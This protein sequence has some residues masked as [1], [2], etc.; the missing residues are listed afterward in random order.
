MPDERLKRTGDVFIEVDCE[1]YPRSKFWRS[2]FRLDCRPDFSHALGSADTDILRTIIRAGCCVTR[3]EPQMRARR[4]PESRHAPKAAGQRIRSGLLAAAVAVLVAFTAVSAHAL[5]PASKA[6]PIEFQADQLTYDSRNRITIATGNVEAVQQGR[7]VVADKMTYDEPRNVLTAEGNVVLYEPTG[8]VVHA[9]SMQLTGD[10]KNAIIEN[11]RAVLADGSR[12]TAK[13]GERIGGTVTTAEDGSYTPCFA[14]AEDPERTP[15]WQVRAVRVTH[16][17]IEKTIEFS[18]AWLEFVGVPVGYVPYLTQPDPS[19]KRK[20]G[21]LIPTFGESSDLGFLIQ[22]PYFVVLSDS[23]DM[24]ITPWFTSN[25][26]PVLEAQYRQALQHGKIDFRGSGTYDSQ[27]RALGHVFGEARYDIDETWRAGLDVQRATGRT[28][29]RRYNFDSQRTLTSR[30]YGE[31]FPNASDYFIGR[32]IAFQNQEHDTDDKNIPYVAPWLDYFLV[33]DKDPLGGQTEVRLDSAVLT[34]EQGLDTRRL[35][36]RAEWRR[37]FVGPIGDLVTVSGAMWADGYNVDDLERND[38]NSQFSGNSGRLFPQ[39]GVEWRLP[40]VRQGEAVHQVIEPITEV[41]LAPTYGNSSRIPNED[42]QDFELQD[43]NLFGFH[44]LPGIDRVDKGP[45]VNYGLNY[46]LYAPGGKSA[47]AF[48]GQSYSFTGDDDFGKGTGLEDKTSDIVSALDLTPAP[49]FDIVY[50]N[51]I[52]HSSFKFERN[53]VG[54]R[55][56]NEALKLHGT[57]VRYESQPQNDLV[58][59]EEVEYGLDTRW[60]RFWRTRAFGITDIRSESQRE[61]GLRAIYEDECFLFSAEFSRENFKDKDVE[62]TNVVFFRVGFKTL[63]DIGAG[64]NPGGS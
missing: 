8:E 62:P 45:R 54:A 39:A 33:T 31:A 41:I 18:H 13:Q 23:Q 22:V 46:T 32:A 50:R 47:S 57:Y 28:Y 58:G 30:L 49:W 6:Q 25:E 19:V 51:R 14:C 26:G 53:E 34:R 5:E 27:D 61:I 10:L 43:T 1:L 16:D 55:L 64:V 4:I 40:L 15:L 42:S 48:V 20:S 2:R 44:R 9:T 3:I 60:T 24:T 21:V 17:Q 37:P 36:A 35:S 59:R 12:I 29:L 11:M 52:D 56:G 7:R 63:G 38:G